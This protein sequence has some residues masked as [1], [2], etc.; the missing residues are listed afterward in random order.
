MAE[1]LM[2]RMSAAASS[3]GVIELSFIRQ[4]VG[5]YPLLA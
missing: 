4:Q 5:S 3:L 1:V 2:V